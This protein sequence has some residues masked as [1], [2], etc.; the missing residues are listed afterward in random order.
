MDD[1][2]TGNDVL[3]MADALTAAGHR[4]VLYAGEHRLS[5]PVYALTARL[6]NDPLDLLIYHHSCGCGFISEVFETARYPKAVKYHNITPLEFFPEGSS[7]YR[8]CAIGMTQTAGLL[9][10]ADA[11]WADSEFN[12]GELGSL[13][14]GIISEVIPP[15]HRV[16]E[17]LSHPPDLTVASVTDLSVP[18]AVVVGRVVPNKDALT[19]VAAVADYN[20]RHGQLRLVVAGDATHPYAAEVRAAAARLG[21]GD[22]FVL[23]GKLTRPRLAT[24]YRMADV[25]LAP[26][27]HEGF[28]VPLVEAMAFGVPAVCRPGTALSETGAGVARFCGGGPAEWSDAIREVLSDP[29][30]HAAAGRRKYASHYHADAIRATFLAA[31]GRLLPDA[32]GSDVTP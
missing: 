30:T 16:E 5:R 14:P 23:A 1:D 24:L 28:C 20:R 6:A 26:S 10:D 13:K 29:A 9:A 15:F 31:V 8:S 12:L 4:V 21:L 3:G 18:T 27:R 7:A 32:G 22:R 17:L 11:V 19:A 2:G 25:F